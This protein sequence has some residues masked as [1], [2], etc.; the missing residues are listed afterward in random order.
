MFERSGPGWQVSARSHMSMLI[1]LYLR[2][3]AGIRRASPALCDSPQTPM[4]SPLSPPVK[5]RAADEFSRAEFAELC[6]EWHQWWRRIVTR[7]DADGSP[8]E[9]E[10][11][12]PG[13]LGQPHF[14]AYRSS[15]SLQR[16]LRAH[17]GAA[18]DW[19]HERRREYNALSR[20]HA[21][22][23]R[24]QV[25]ESLV[26]ERSLESDPQ[27]V[28]TLNMIELPLAERRA[29]LVGDRTV[30]LSQELVRDE[31]L[32]RSYLEPMIRLIR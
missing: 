17:Y 30:I 1:A 9:T 23:G 8:D 5:P 11:P 15:P 10:T 20:E 3:L 6:Q 16:L 25:L 27:D 7:Y 28:L 24:R 13:L 26:E 14:N 19:S 21:A 32:L 18:T 4:L 29:W 31:R 12:E 22:A 2:D